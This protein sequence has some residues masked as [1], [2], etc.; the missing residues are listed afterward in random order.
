MLLVI[1]LILLILFIFYHVYWKRRYLPPGPVPL[2]FL[3]NIIQ[4]YRVLPGYEAFLECKRTYGDVFTFWIGGNPYIIIASLDLMKETFVKDGDAYAEKSQ[5][6]LQ[7]KMRGGSYGIIDTNGHLWREHRRFALTTLRDF[8]LGKA[9]MQEKI[10][11]EIRESFKNLQQLQGQEV[12]VTEYLDRSVGNVINLVLF[13]YRFEG[14]KAWELDH[15]KGLINYQTETFSKFSILLQSY[16]PILRH[17]MPR[18]NINDKIDEF[19]QKFYEFFNRQIMEHK[20]NIDY[21]AVD[22]ADFVEAY[23][24]EQRKRERDGDAVTFCDLQLSNV[25]L[26]LWFA[27]LVTTTHTLSWAITYA[28]NYPETIEKVQRE[29]DEVISSNRLITTSD[30][31]ELPYLSAFINETQRC[32]N[33]LPINVLHRTARDTVIRGYPIKQSTGVIA[34][35]STVMLDEKVFP[36][37]YQ[38][39]PDRFIENG[40]L[41]RIEELIPFSIGKRQCLGEGLARMELFLFLANFFNQ[42]KICPSSEGLPSMSKNHDFSMKPKSFKVVLHSRFL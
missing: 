37:P 14:E 22:N 9:V 17:L 28:L 25:I 23:L 30:K 16:I 15:M 19:K 8:G 1:S 12:E 34:Q 42:F 7:L 13:G 40:K 26:D 24:K 38:F 31:N 3:G 29:L 32:A 20:E 6:E 27:G 39:N 2:P 18:P 11:L 36:E 33:I 10:L 41:K 4:L 21:D 5:H 35:I